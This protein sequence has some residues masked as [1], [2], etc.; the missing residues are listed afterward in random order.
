MNDNRGERGRIIH[1]VF[2]VILKLLQ[3]RMKLMKFDVKLSVVLYKI[4]RRG[5]I[6]GLRKNTGRE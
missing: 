4:K 6:K 3:K 1:F 5:A 2:E